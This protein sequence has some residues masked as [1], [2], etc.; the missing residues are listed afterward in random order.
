MLGNASLPLLFSVLA[1]SPFFLSSLL[2]LFLL[3]LPPHSCPNQILSP[4]THRRYG[5][6]SVRGCVL[7]RPGR[8]G[9]EWSELSGGRKEV[10][11]WVLFPPG[12]L[13]FSPFT[14]H[15]YLLSPSMSLSIF[16]SPLFIVVSGIQEC[17]VEMGLLNE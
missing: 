6:V 7:L 10:S 15:Q 14:H 5:Q 8:L 17:S 4:K 2:L 16:A 12:S 13:V 3:P 11:I 1:L 9:G